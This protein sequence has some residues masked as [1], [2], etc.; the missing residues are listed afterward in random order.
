M[1]NSPSLWMTQAW[2]KASGGEHGKTLV[3]REMDREETMQRSSVDNVYRVLEVESA[4]CVWKV[5]R[6]RKGKNGKQQPRLYT[7][8][9]EPSAVCMNSVPLDVTCK[10]HKT[11]RW[12]YLYR[13]PRLKSNRF[14]IRRVVAIV[15]SSYVDSYFLK[16]LEDVS[17]CL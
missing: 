16:G 9:A 1:G 12:Q 4:T 6:G 3:Y 10:R 5:Q 17:M 2:S 11:T 14:N 15:P 8:R 7:Q 13:D